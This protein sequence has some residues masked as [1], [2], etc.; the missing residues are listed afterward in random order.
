MTVTHEITVDEAST[1]Q[2]APNVAHPAK[3]KFWLLTLVGLYPLLT[4][5]VTVT[6]P[7]LEPLPTPLRLA[8]ILPVAVAA[9][10][11]GIMPVL[12]RCFAG[13]LMR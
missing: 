6:G 11:W 13:W 9:M 10:V 5:L 7:L 12:T 2:G 8:C 1:E 3:W 4:G